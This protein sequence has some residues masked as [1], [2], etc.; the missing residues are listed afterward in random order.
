MPKD[1]LTIYRAA[2]ELDF[3]VGGKV[4]KVN[5]PNADTLILLFH[6]SVGNHRLLLSC[7]PSLPRVHVT[8]AQY[9]NPETATGT[10]MYFRKRLAGAIL[11]GIEKDK[12]E[13]MITF[14]FSAL[15]ELRERVEYSL[16]A[17]LTGKC[18][19]IVFVES[20]G[21]IGNCLRRISSEAPGKRA[22]LDRKSVV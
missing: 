22:V 16:I 17:E 4:D 14:K 8:R 18:T 13:R 19:N 7:N 1:A 20:D 10:L 15:D 2:C 11:V 6:T 3:L 9:K 21:A 5:M 12:C